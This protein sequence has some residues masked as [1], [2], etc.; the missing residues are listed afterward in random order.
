[1]SVNTPDLIFKG[2]L[3]LRMER[4]DPHLMLT[5]N[6][7][8]TGRIQFYWVYFYYLYSQSVLVN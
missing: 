8:C 5:L 2:G 1:M 3:E 7:K 6:N 4:V